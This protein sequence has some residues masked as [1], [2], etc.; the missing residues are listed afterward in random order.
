[1]KQRVIRQSSSETKLK[2]LASRPVDVKAQK[3]FDQ[4]ASSFSSYRTAASNLTQA[5]NSN[6]AEAAALH[7]SHSLPIIR[8]TKADPPAP[9]ENG[10][11]ADKTVER[12]ASH[13]DVHDLD[14]NNDEEKKGI[15]LVT[16]LQAL[17]LSPSFQ[18]ERLKPEEVELLNTILQRVSGRGEAEGTK[19]AIPKGLP[20]GIALIA[21]AHKDSPGTVDAGE[22]EEAMSTHQDDQ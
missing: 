14:F 16:L 3:E 2:S 9:F 12:S 21:T 4:L 13:P 18:D 20:Q 7:R 11:S 5:R 19:P 6:Q 8:S 17:L 1:M 22:H 15:E 10:K